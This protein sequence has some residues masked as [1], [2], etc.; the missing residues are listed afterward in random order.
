M[1]KFTVAKERSLIDDG[2]LGSFY[3]YVNNK[4]VSRTGIG[5][6][7]D[8]KGILLEHDADKA[9]CFN[10]YFSSVF[11]VDDNFSPPVV[12]KAPVN[13]FTDISFTFDSVRKAVRSLKA[14]HSKGPDG[15]SSFFLK[16]LAESISFPLMLIF[17]QSFECGNLPD[18]WKSAIVTPVFKKGLASDVSNYRPISLTCTCCKVMEAVIKQQLL[19]YLLSKRLISK[20]QHG[21]LARHSTC[22]Q[23]LECTNDWTMALNSRNSVDV[24][25]LDFSKAFDSVCHAKLCVKLKSFGIG[26]K[27]L[28]WITEYLNNRT[29]VVKVGDSL[30]PPCH[31]TSG[32]PQGSVLGPLLFLVFINDI[33]DEFGDFL[34]V[35]LFADD[36]KIY[37]IVDDLIKT[38]VLQLALDKLH[39]WSLKWQLKIAVHK[40]F[41]LHIGATNCI[42]R[43]HLNNIMLDDVFEAR[44]LGVT[45]DNNLRFSKH[46]SA[47]VTKAHQRSALIMRCF[48]SRDPGLLFRAFTVYV[49]PILEYCAPV[50]NPMYLCDIRRIEA[51]QR[52]FTKRLENMHELSYCDRLAVLGAE[53]LEVRRLKADLI[54]MYKCLFCSIALEPEIMF[55]V[56]DNVHNTRGHRFKLVKPSCRLNCRLNNFT[57]RNIDIWNSLSQTVFINSTLANFKSRLNNIDFSAFLRVF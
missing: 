36:V 19:A 52:R 5:A 21:F 9:E 33:V 6:V 22:T 55:T 15:L 41:V 48:K 1:Y 16:Q 3:K 18:I 23:L 38:D 49:R 42:H 25:Y 13:S 47:I 44:D 10:K 12:D 29:Q 4:V 14:K 34:H 54:L 35:K 39:S 17:S 45:I 28:S 11:T 46:I 31:V 53:S 50:W 7:K 57:C 40:C 8:S 24:A 2:N 26:G 51:V 27:L 43:Y 32:V 56:S 37:V 30:S 20:H